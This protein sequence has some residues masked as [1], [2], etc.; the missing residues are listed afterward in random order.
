M[1][2]GLDDGKLLGDSQGD[3]REL[4]SPQKL[5]RRL[6]YSSGLARSGQGSTFVLVVPKVVEGFQ[7]IGS[8]EIHPAVRAEKAGSAAFGAFIHQSGPGNRRRRQ[9]SQWGSFT[10]IVRSRF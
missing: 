2:N 9:L 5:L 7:G 8:C 10:R 4:C 6:T 1:V 3:L